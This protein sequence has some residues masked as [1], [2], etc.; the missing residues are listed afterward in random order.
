MDNEIKISDNQ[1]KPINQVHV[2]LSR[3]LI[4]VLAII[5]FLMFI[6][7]GSVTLFSIFPN[8]LIKFVLVGLVAWLASLVLQILIKKPRPYESGKKVMMKPWM[9]TPSFPSSHATI[10]FAL[11]SYAFL[12]D[13]SWG[14]LILVLLAMVISAARV[15]TGYHY[16]RDVMAGAILGIL[17]ALGGIYLFNFS[18]CYF[19]LI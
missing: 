18:N 9:Y 15:V 12:L 8:E 4:F 13:W 19:C 11:A 10:S 6:W 3:Y 2:F 14:G 1:R 5:I 7:D 16:V 17:I